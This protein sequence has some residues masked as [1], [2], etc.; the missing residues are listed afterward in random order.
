M[1]RQSDNIEYT[2]RYSDNELE[3]V[4]RGAGQ[5]LRIQRKMKGW[6]QKRLAEQG[7]VTISTI[8]RVE[9]GL[10]DKTDTLRQVAEGLGGE[11]Y[12][13]TIVADLVEEF[14]QKRPENLS[15]NE[16]LVKES[17]TDGEEVWVISP[18]LRNDIDPA[19]LP[20][21]EE[22]MERDICYRLIVPKYE[23]EDKSRDAQNLREVKRELMAKFRKFYEKKLYF[24]D[25]PQNDFRLLTLTS[26]QILLLNPT[27]SKG[28]LPQVFLELPIGS[29]WWI[30]MSSEHAR[31]FRG[32]LHQLEFQ[33]PQLIGE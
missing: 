4:K 24:I 7:T 2:P 27:M 21:V 19:V 3:Y 32:K 17:K 30:E 15:L 8:S 12:F 20:I 33:L 26:T 23:E 13:D 25:I 9:T 28:E 29:S 14:R 6:T 18:D 22:N 1:A 10:I 31:E 5:T 11:G 16:I